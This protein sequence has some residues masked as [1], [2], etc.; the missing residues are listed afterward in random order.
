VLGPR[1]FDV[2]L[3]PYRD[4]TDKITGI[5]TDIHDLTDRKQAEDAL[6]QHRDNLE[7][8]VEER[9]TELAD[10]N[11]ELE[12]FSYSVSHDLRAPLRHMDGYS[13]IL[14]EDY[15]EVLDDAGKDLLNTLRKSSQ[16]MAQLIEDLLTLSRVSREEIVRKSVDLSADANLIA[17]QLHT[18]YPDRDVSI[19]IQQGLRANGDPRLLH[20]VLTNL[21]ENA[22]KYTSRRDKAS[23]EVGITT[24]RGKK[25]FYVKDNGAGF[26]MQFADKLF[27]PFQRLHGDDEFPGTGIGLASVHRIIKRH[28]GGIWAEGKENEGATF[29]FTLG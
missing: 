14:L 25:V 13:Q 12:A 26:N 16:R 18:T 20:I 5:V 23:I 9:T 11:Q 21:L 19:V 3:I 8:L 10:T 15:A 29:Y 24:S 22:W 4:T 2:T 1:Y 6:A 7:K 17:E 28:H 27:S